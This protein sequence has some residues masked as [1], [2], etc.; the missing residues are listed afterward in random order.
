MTPIH[1]HFEQTERGYN[2]SINDSATTLLT[3]RDDT[4]NTIYSA[5]K[6][7]DFTTHAVEF[8]G[9]PVPSMDRLVLLV[10]YML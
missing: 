3:S 5:V 7:T 6:D 2:L 8:N 9:M 10:K 1:I 4:W